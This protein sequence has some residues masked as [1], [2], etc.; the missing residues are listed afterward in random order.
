MQRNF[1][2]FYMQDTIYINKLEELTSKMQTAYI[3]AHTAHFAWLKERKKGN[4]IRTG[5][6]RNVI[7]AVF[8]ICNNWQWITI[9]SQTTKNTQSEIWTYCFFLNI[10]KS[11]SFPSNWYALC[12][13]EWD[14]KIQIGN[15]ECLVMRMH[16]NSHIKW[17]SCQKWLI[18]KASDSK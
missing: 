10:W 13:R 5:S 15:K 11:F 12:Y 16:L 17:E 8:G 1:C 7:M 14:T 2:I 9:W 4:F 3:W 6:T 18:K